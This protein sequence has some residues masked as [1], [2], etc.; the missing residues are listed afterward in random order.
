MCGSI[1]CTH[2]ISTR[3]QWT[4]RL[5]EEEGCSRCTHN[6]QRAEENTGLPGG[7]GKF[8]AQ[9]KVLRTGFHSTSLTLSLF[10]ITLLD[11][12]ICHTHLEHWKNTLE[13]FILIAKSLECFCDTLWKQQ[14]FGSQRERTV[15]K[16]KQFSNE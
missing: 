2:H 9:V 12:A 4:A 3:F 14:G 10:Y 8:A 13:W 1:L 6:G 16:I 11:R 15:D 7:T 5:K